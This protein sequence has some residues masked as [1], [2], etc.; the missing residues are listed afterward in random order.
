MTFLDRLKKALLPI[1]TAAPAPDVTNTRLMNELLA[2]FD[3]SVQQESVGSSLLFNM[4]Y[5]IILH[6]DTYNARLSSLPV[7]VKETV[8]AF[9]K[10][11]SEL[12]NQYEEISPVS[13]NWQFKFGPGVSF[14]NETIEPNDILVIGTLTGVKE[15]G[16]QQNTKATVK[17]K[18]TNVF[19]RM[20]INLDTL[21]HI[22]FNE[23]GSFTVKF[24]ADL[25]LGSESQPRHKEA[26]LARISYHLPEQDTDEQFTMQVREIV[27]ARKEPENMSY[28]NYLLI[29]SLYVSNPHARIRYHESTRQFQI[30]SFSRNET[31]VNERIIPRSDLTDPQWL[32]LPNQAQ[33]LL[34]GFITLHFD[35]E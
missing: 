20:D 12:R 16:Y 19:D 3:A 10:R 15:G 2:C 34:N 4:H 24:N 7:V 32:E 5:L 26:G 23:S 35:G 22:D 18:R 1:D 9:Y 17:P 33:I 29:D 25:Q 27:I 31:R 28:S 30:A 11:L 6:P 13:A 8:K 21:R 14:N